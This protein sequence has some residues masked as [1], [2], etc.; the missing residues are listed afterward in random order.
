MKKKK[1]RYISRDGWGMIALALMFLY[2]PARM[3]VSLVWGV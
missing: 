1:T 2:F 3:I